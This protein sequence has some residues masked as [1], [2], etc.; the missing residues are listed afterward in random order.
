MTTTE[1]RVRA[2]RMQAAAK[3][4]SHGDA[5]ER[6]GIIG[7]HYAR[8]ANIGAHLEKLSE[9]A[10]RSTETK[11]AMSHLYSQLVND[12]EHTFGHSPMFDYMAGGT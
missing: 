11:A 9:F 8:C 1:G 12:Y 6:A 10:D 4:F 5:V 7:R 3:H 2:H